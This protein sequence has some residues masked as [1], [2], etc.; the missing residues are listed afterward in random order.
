MKCISPRGWAVA[1]VA[2]GLA[3]TAQ[4]ANAGWVSY[5]FTHSNTG[6]ISSFATVNVY[7]AADYNALGT[8]ATAAAGSV[9]ITLDITPPASGDLF[10]LYLNYSNAITNLNNLVFTGLTSQPAWTPAG[11]FLSA[12]SR[13]VD[14]VNSTDLQNTD[15][16]PIDAVFD[17]GL[18]F[19]GTGSPPPNEPIISVTVQ[20][21][22]NS[23]TLGFADFVTDS[24]A[25]DVFGELLF[26]LRA[27]STN[28]QGGSL[29]AFVTDD[30]TPGGGSGG[31]GSVVPAPAG[32]IL[33]ASAV[34]VLAFRRLIRRKPVAA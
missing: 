33:L 2:I 32:L 25:D 31:G 19:G 10:A 9:V 16:E 24:E 27:Q 11:A 1:L 17:I 20:I 7:D 3:L 14:S 26:G 21:T 8:G 29:K 30:D 28:T 18:Q 5:D 13:G 23:G 12:V 6:N 15:I 22:T 34:P 4:P